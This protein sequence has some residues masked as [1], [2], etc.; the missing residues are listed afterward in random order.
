MSE[1]NRRIIALNSEAFVVPRGSRQSHPD[2]DDAR[3]K[4]S[5][6]VK[7]ISRPDAGPKLDQTLKPLFG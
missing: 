5:S 3:T 1:I 4:K 2:N 6:S 7:E